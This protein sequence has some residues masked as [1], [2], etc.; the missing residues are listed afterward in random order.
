MTKEFLFCTGSNKTS[1]L[2]YWVGQD[3]KV[4]L[5]LIS[6]YNWNEMWD[7]DRPVAHAHV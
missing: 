2:F 7:T 4:I 1:E 6:K 3:H 5:E